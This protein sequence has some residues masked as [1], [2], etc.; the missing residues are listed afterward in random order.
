MYL[1]WL[2]PTDA[3]QSSSIFASNDVLKVCEMISWKKVDIDGGRYEIDPDS[4]IKT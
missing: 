4:S 1:R 2:T 3:I